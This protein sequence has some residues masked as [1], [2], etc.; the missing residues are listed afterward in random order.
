MRHL[1]HPVSSNLSHRFTH[2]YS[3]KLPTFPLEALLSEDA[4]EREELCDLFQIKHCSVVQLDNS[5]RL[6]V[7]GAAAAI[8]HEPAKKEKTEGHF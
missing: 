4:D 5:Q 3:L 1:V 2:L 6:L 7:I 8:R